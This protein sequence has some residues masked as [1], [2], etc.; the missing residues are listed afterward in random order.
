MYARYVRRHLVGTETE[1]ESLVE[2]LTSWTVLLQS[3]SDSFDGARELGRQIKILLDKV[4]LYFH[5]KGRGV[6]LSTE[7]EFRVSID[8]YDTAWSGHIEFEISIVWHHIE[9]SKCSSSEQCVIA[10]T[11]GDDVKDQ[12]FALEVVQESEDDF[13]C[14]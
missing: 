8:C 10:T 14:D 12:V 3:S 4:A 13:Q 7:G 5:Y 6:L 2:L 11:E 1:A 9:S